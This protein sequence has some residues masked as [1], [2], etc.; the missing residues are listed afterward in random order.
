MNIEDR[1]SVA[2]LLLIAAQKLEKAAAIMMDNGRNRN[3]CTLLTWAG[4]L[5]DY[6]AEQ[7]K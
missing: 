1:E 5:K 2:T 4:D 6:A 3:A 7:K